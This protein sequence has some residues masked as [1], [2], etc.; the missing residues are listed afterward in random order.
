MTKGEC[1]LQTFRANELQY[2]FPIFMKEGH[3]RV[4]NKVKL[5]CSIDD[6]RWNI[7]KFKLVAV[8]SF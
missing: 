6:L 3:R 7:R 4:T 5:T 8:Y 2:G 1:R